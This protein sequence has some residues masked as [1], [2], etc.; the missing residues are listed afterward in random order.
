MTE[1][2]L[3]QSESEAVGEPMEEWKPADVL[4]VALRTLWDAAVGCSSGDR[5]AME[6][7][8]YRARWMIAA[9]GRKDVSA[10]V[11]D[12]FEAMTIEELASECNR[13]LDEAR[14]RMICTAG[15]E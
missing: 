5:V 15:C 9:S 2:D 3:D 10:P 12:G 4:D 1:G 7:A 8:L 11:A 13:R 6:R 14:Q